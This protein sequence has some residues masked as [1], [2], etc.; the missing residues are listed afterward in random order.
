[1]HSKQAHV[2]GNRF[3]ALSDEELVTLS[4][5]GQTDAQELLLRRYKNLVRAKSRTYFLMGADNDDVIQEGMVG[6]YKATR[7]YSGDK[8]CSFKSFA[9]LCITRQIITAIKAAGRNKHMPLNSYISLNKPVYD[10]DSDRTLVDLMSQTIVSDPEEIILINEAID[11][12]AAKVANEFSPFERRVLKMYLEGCRYHDIAVQTGHDLKSIDNAI[13]RV[14][15][16][17]SK[18]KN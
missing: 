17:L 15:K 2:Q 9:E 1:M 4:K 13:Q 16:K 10:G 18:L 5:A 14:K 3:D 6:L 11:E 8:Q 12:I 7:D